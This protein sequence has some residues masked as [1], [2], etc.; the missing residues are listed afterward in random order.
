M[1]KSSKDKSSKEL[2]REA[3]TIVHLLHCI[4]K[5]CINCNEEIPRGEAAHLIDLA[6]LRLDEFNDL[7]QNMH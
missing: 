1:D 6:K 3:R 2:M 5:G 7:D 4:V